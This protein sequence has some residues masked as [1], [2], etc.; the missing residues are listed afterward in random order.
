MTAGNFDKALIA[1]RDTKPFRL[2]TVELIG[3]RRVEV[4]HPNAFVV[5]DGVAIFVAPGGY[6]VIFDHD[7][8]L[9]FIGA[10]STTDV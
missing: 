1:M 10:A 4:D 9:R 5:R 6:P 3:G 7:S 8:V 2:F